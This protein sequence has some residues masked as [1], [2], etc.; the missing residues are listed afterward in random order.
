MVQG[1]KAKH[2]QNP[3]HHAPTSNIISNL[4]QMGASITDA[5]LIEICIYFELTDLFSESMPS[6]NHG[7]RQATQKDIDNFLL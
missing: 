6:S 7:P 4:A 3:T 5:H 2:P 1:R